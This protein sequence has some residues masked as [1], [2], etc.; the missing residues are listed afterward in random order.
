MRCGVGKPGEYSHVPISSGLPLS[1]IVPF[2]AGEGPE[3]HEENTWDRSQSD[4]ISAG[5]I[6]E[7][8]SDIELRSA[9]SKAV[10]SW[11]ET[12]KKME[13]KELYFSN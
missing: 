8:K 1:S 6:L 2:S 5:A 7:E 12:C 10:K 4:V 3:V 13:Q 11:E 9:L